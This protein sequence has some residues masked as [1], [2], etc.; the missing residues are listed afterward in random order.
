MILHMVE[1]LGIEGYQV[2]NFEGLQKVLDNHSVTHLFI[3]QSEYEENSFYYEELGCTLPVVVIA[4]RDFLMSRDSRLM[5]IRKPFFA[6]SVVNLLNGMIGENEFKE[7]Q[8]AGRKPF[9]CESVHVLL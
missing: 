4:E 3:A 5:V 9:S 2:H 1:G 7:A 6:L 8:V